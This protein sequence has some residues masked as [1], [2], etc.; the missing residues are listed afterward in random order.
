[1]PFVGI[2]FD[3]F[4]YFSDKIAIEDQLIVSFLLNFSKNIFKNRSYP[5]DVLLIDTFSI[6]ERH[7]NQILAP[8]IVTFSNCVW[9]ILSSVVLYHS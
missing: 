6:E 3:V 2:V 7:M 9:Q 1:M 4:N 8:S 5:P